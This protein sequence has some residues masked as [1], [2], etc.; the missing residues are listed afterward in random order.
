MVEV[1]IVMNNIKYEMIDRKDRVN[2]GGE[3]NTSMP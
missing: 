1:T 3:W 2:A